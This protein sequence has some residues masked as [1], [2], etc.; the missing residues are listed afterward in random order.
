MLDVELQTASHCSINPIT[1]RHTSGA[2]DTSEADDTSVLS[3]V[4][5]EMMIGI[6]ATFH[7]AA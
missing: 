2:E 6:L 5:F 7:F 1:Q 3:E 4:T